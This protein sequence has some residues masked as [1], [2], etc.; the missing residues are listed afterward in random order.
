MSRKNTLIVA[1]LV[2]AC[3]LTLLFVTA[4]TQE[5]PD[6]KTSF[7]IV[8]MTPDKVKLIEEEKDVRT[9][10]VVQKK[11]ETSLPEV[12]HR[13]PPISKIPEEKEVKASKQSILPQE[14]RKSFVIKV[15]PGDSLEKIA[16]TYHCSVHD[17][18][19]ANNLPSTFL[20]VGQSLT[21]PQNE[22][23]VALKVE[24]KE[25]E[26]SSEEAAYYTVKSGDNP[27]TIAMKHHIKVE[28]LLRLN[29]LNEKKAKRLRPGDKL[30]IR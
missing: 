20:K 4:A 30:R 26:P 21:I 6:S 15:K 1:I 5:V 2:N 9:P 23:K 29:K 18:L 12:V 10:I 3:L 11:E 13:L 19:R 28:E 24:P 17:I 16:K 25:E 7:P 27:W 8:R 14:I 22:K